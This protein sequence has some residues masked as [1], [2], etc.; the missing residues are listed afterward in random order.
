MTRQI[1]GMRIAASGHPEQVNH[2]SK[3]LRGARIPF[4]V[5]R[6][7]VEESE[8]Y[9]ELWVEEEDIAKARTVIQNAGAGVSLMLW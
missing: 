2:L 6:P 3:A 4:A 7:H 9:S 1:N 5:A 8:E